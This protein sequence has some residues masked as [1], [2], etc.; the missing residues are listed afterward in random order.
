MT[1]RK[2]FNYAEW[3]IDTIKSSFTTIYSYCICYLLS[4]EI[5]KNCRFYGKPYIKVS[6][7][8][9]IK[10]GN[11]CVFRSSKISNFIGLNHNC[12]IVAD[13]NLK[14]SLI[15]NIRIGNNCG[16]SG[17]SIWSY[18]SI[19]IGDNVR[20]GANCLIMDHDAHIDDPRTAAPAEIV[21]E[22]NVFIGA[23]CTI[24]KGVHIG[25]NS[26][27]GMNSIVTKDIPSNCIAV[28]SPAKAI[29]IIV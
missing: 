6:K 18:K 24:K 23:N 4:V 5:G 15:G 21:I 3:K 27:I 14:R 29:K 17:V 8:S 10:I 7:Q 13:E 12:I 1:F 20:V 28:G 22:N 25:E 11:C 9:S 26:V 16:F 19:F 2:L